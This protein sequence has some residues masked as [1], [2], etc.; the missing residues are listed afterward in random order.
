[1]FK[2]SNLSFTCIR[3]FVDMMCSPVAAPPPGPPGGPPGPVGPPG[4]V[5]VPP[6]AMGLVPP[7]QPHQ[8]PQPP[9]LPSKSKFQDTCVIA[10]PTF[11]FFGKWSYVLDAAVTCLLAYLITYSLE[12]SPS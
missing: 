3:Q 9:E 11:T 7:Q 6:G 1:M 8:P 5:A 10:C 4:A 2:V 12:Q